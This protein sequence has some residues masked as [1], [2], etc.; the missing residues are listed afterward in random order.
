M[1]VKIYEITLLGKDIQIL[2]DNIL[3]A[4]LGNLCGIQTNITDNK[5]GKEKL[6][7]EICD[8]IH[9]NI[10]KLTKMLEE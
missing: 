5:D 3:Y 4:T 2:S 6:I 1:K 7:V 10:D 8:R 9:E